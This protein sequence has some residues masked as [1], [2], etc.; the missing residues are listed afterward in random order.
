MRR[1]HD[2]DQF[3]GSFRYGNSIFKQVTKLS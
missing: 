3:A 1:A 2:V